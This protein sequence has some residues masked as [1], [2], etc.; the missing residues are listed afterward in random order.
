MSNVQ[1]NHPS[2]NNNG[3][4]PKGGN[5]MTAEAAARIQH[6][7]AKANNGNVPKGAFACR[8]QRAAA[9]NANKYT[10]GK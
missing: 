7:D 6:C 1:G 4:M 10:S 5:P 2:A 9:N 8:A 3:A